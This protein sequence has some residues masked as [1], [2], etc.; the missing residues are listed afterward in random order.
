LLAIAREAAPLRNVGEGNHDAGDHRVIHSNDDNDARYMRR[1]LDLARRGWGQA[2]PN[3]MV[4]AVVVRDGEIVGEGW[5]VRYGADHAEPVALAAAGDRARGATLYVTLEPCTHEG[6]RPPC[7]P[8]V[9]ASRLSRVVIATLDPNPIAGGGAQLLRDA[10]IDVSIGVEEDE[11]RELNAPFLHRF[12]SDRPWVTLKLALS[13]DGALA[14]PGRTPRWITGEESRLEVHRQRAGADAIAVGIG[15][16]LADDP[17]L[18]VRGVEP[19][20]VPPM[21]VVFDRAARLPVGSRMIRTI[22]DAPLTVITDGSVPERERVLEG[23]GATVIRATGTAEALRALKQMGIDS[24]YAEGGAGLVGEFLDTGSVDRLIIFQSPVVLGAGA[25]GAFDRS[26]S[27][28][29][30]QAARLRIVRRERFGDD[31]MT[32]YALR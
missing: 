25:L 21:R 17:L 11:A 14:N 6:K 16:V 18:T 1:A 29:L 2:A 13:R 5:H 30:E 23:A 27:F 10:G 28:T 7:T 8:R 24:L 15:T 22:G 12:T 4:G 9:I 19:P 3:P 20:R 31:D 26:R 32:I